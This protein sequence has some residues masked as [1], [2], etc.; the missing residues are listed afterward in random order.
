MNLQKLTLTE[1]A[2]AL[3]A[4]KLTSRSLVEALLAR[5]ETTDGSIGAYASLDAERAR[6]EADAADARRAAGKILSRFDG[7]PIAMK[8]NIAVKD[9]VVQCG[10]KILDGLKSTYDA[11]VVSRL[12]AAGVIP[13]GRSNMDEF[14]MGSTSENSQIKTTRNPWNAQRVPG[15]SSGG[16]AAGVAAGSM[17][18]ALGSDT[19]GSIRQP[20]AFCG[21]VGLKPTY[22]TVSR[23]GLVA[24]ASSLDQIGPV[25]RDVRDC[26]ELYDLIAGHDPMDSTSIP[27]PRES[28]VAALAQD[29]K[30][31]RVGLPKEWLE[32]DGLDPECRAAVEKAVKALE[33]RGASVVPVA[34]PHTKYAI[35][36]YY[37]IATAEASTNLARFDG[38][39]YG[40][41]VEGKRLEG[42]TDILSLY[43]STRAQGFGKEV[44]RRILLGTFVL[45]KGYADR[46]Y[47]QAQK[48]RTLI[49]RDFDAAFAQCDVIAGPVAPGVAPA[50]GD[51]KDPIKAYLSDVL[52]IGVNLAGLPALSVPCGLVHGLPVGLQLV[53]PALA[54]NTLIRTAAA[55]E[56][57]FSLAAAPC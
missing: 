48:V 18:A 4:G 7:L 10:S 6:R 25:T 12:R 24:Y 34:L 17:L 51:L 31:L 55:V 35:P 3:A 1:A 8:D 43:K 39:R 20:A 13:M 22:G 27:G 29:V 19:G 37:V 54:E 41:R 53:G 42:E 28:A 2:E 46:Y 36:A 23:F 49:K 11:T 33:A 14:A 26:A 52:T 5:T 16:A 56:K 44:Q 50:F 45:S 38:I 57:D 47:L 30:G 21:T 15:G 40:N 9:E 32:V